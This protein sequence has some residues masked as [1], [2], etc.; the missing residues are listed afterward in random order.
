MKGSRL[1]MFAIALALGSV[2]EIARGD[3]LGTAFTYQGELK[4]AGLPADSDYDF[5]F[6]LFD[7]PNSGAQ[8]GSD[9][10]VDD[11]PVTDGLFT[12]E[13]D[14]GAGVFTSDARWLEIDVRD[15]A[16]GSEY[17]TLSPRQALTPTPYASTALQTV[18]VDG[19]SLDA[20]DGSP[21]D[22][23]LVDSDGRVR[24]EE[25]GLTVFDAVGQGI[26]LTSDSFQFA[27]GTSEDPVYD[28]SSTTLTHR[29]WTNG[30]RQ[31]VITADGGV[32]IGT[33]NPESRLHVKTTAG[34]TAIVGDTASPSGT[35]IYGWASNADLWDSSNIGVHGRSDGDNNAVGVYGEATNPNPDGTT[36]GVRGVS[37][38]GTGVRGENTTTGSYGSLGSLSFGVR[39]VA[40]GG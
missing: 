17:T 18:G 38:E 2:I 19:H 40:Y 26:R 33:D 34:A 6:R 20:A 10:P 35:A 7:D 8:I 23:V 30:S 12:V 4:D 24:M 16:G 37:V 3:V 9:F 31:M 29:F 15:S 22:A 32:G 21:T 27:E 5:V 28:Y 14:F 13:V 39:G 36:Y 11:W 25:G 1:T